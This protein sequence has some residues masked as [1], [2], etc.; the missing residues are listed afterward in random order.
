MAVRNSPL[1]IRNSPLALFTHYA[2]RTTKEFSVNRLDGKTVLV[3]GSSSGIG[4]AIALACAAEGANLALVA[5]RAE[6]LEEVAAQIREMGRTAAICVA[7]VADEAQCLA[8]LAQATEEIGPI[9]VL[10]NNAG[11]NLKNRTIQETTTEEWRRILEVNLTSA[12]VLTKAVLPEMIARQGGTIINIGSRSAML[13]SVFAGVSYSTSK[14]GLDALTQVTNEE[15]NAHG[16][17]ACVIHPGEVETEILVYRK[18][19]VSDERR[20]RMMQGEDIAAA[21]V[22]VASLPPRANID[23]ISIR[24]TRSG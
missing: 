17:R 22:L 23:M 16:V 5:R 20:Q 1:A 4:Q 13:P 7:D 2:P 3:T 12:Y 21:V 8:A 14:I 11:T 18:S 6:R 10:V 9:D 15:G 24:P 19:P